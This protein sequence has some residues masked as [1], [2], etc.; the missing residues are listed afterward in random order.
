METINEFIPT[1][2]EEERK[3]LI[4]D[5]KPADGFLS[6]SAIQTFLSC[7]MRYKLRYL[8]KIEV[9]P[10]IPLVAGIVVHKFLE[11][12][13]LRIHRGESPKKSLDDAALM[14]MFKDV[15]KERGLQTFGDV[16]EADQ[17]EDAKNVISRMLAYW[18]SATPVE[19]GKPMVINNKPCVESYFCVN[20]HKEFYVHGFIDTIFS[21]RVAVDFK[22]SAQRW[23]AYRENYEMQGLVY[24][25]ALN[26]YLGIDVDEFGYLIL[27]KHKKPTDK[28][29]EYRP[30]SLDH[31]HCLYF[32]EKCLPDI[33]EQIGAVNE[34]P[35]KALAIPNKNECH[36]CEY[37]AECPAIPSME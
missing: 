19:L 12:D 25:Y 15:T 29:F 11:D 28:S 5:R 27:V 20:F 16:P 37:R 14:E 7:Q 2:E 3:K 26:K 1:M 32:W 31:D 33:A 23:Q 36:F 4:E 34:H 30:T 22:T 13:L 8:D 17:L 35:E 6:P 18:M 9:P 10:T 21:D 24:P